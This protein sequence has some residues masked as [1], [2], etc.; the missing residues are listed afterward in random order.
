MAR[1]CSFASHQSAAAAALMRSKKGCCVGNLEGI[2]DSDSR[3]YCLQYVN[4]NESETKW[5]AAVLWSKY[6]PGHYQCANITAYCIVADMQGE[7]Y[8]SSCTV[9]ADGAPCKNLNGAVGSCWQGMCGDPERVAVNMLLAADGLRPEAL[10]WGQQT[11][12]FREQ[13]PSMGALDYDQLTFQ[14]ATAADD[15]SYSDDDPPRGSSSGGPQQPPLPQ[16]PP[17]RTQITD[18]SD[19]YGL[20]IQLPPAPKITDPFT[21]RPPS[22]PPPFP[23]PPPPPPV[24]QR[25]SLTVDIQPDSFT[26]GVPASFLGISREWTQAVWWDKNLPAFG[27]IFDVLGPAPVIRI[28][29]ASQ[30]ALLQPPNSTYINSLITLHCA[31]GVRFIIGLPLFQNAPM[32]SLAVKKTFD[33]AFK[34][35]PFAILSYELGNEPNYWPGTKQGGFQPLRGAQKCVPVQYNDPAYELVGTMDAPTDKAGGA[36]GY[37]IYKDYKEPYVP[38]KPSQYCYT[39]ES[40]LFVSGTESYQSYFARAARIITGCGGLQS[41]MQ[42]LWGFPY[43][44]PPGFNRQVISGPSWGDF[45]SFPTEQLATFLKNSDQCYLSEVTMHYYGPNRNTTFKALF[46]NLLARPIPDQ[47]EGPTNKALIS[48]V[49]SYIDAARVAN[50]ALRVSE[51]NS[52]PDGGQSNFSNTL[53]AALWTVSTAMEFA[54]AG[55]SGI[56][57]HWG[58]GGVPPDPGRAPAYI[59]VQTLFENDDWN[60]PQPAVRIPWY[61]YVMFSRALGNNGPGMFLNYTTNVKA[62]SSDAICREQIYYYP[63]L[64]PHAGMVSLVVANVNPNVTC[65]FTATLPGVLTSA[66]VLQRLEGPKGLDSVPG[67]TLAGQTYEQTRDGRMRGQ[68]TP[69]LVQP[70]QESIRQTGWTFDVRPGSGV[71]VQI[72]LAAGTTNQLGMA[73]TT[74]SFVAAAGDG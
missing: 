53:G 64:V 3:N 38:Y 72:P 23:P 14:Q 73:P 67:V 50:V 45:S 27:N 7:Q 74:P 11:Q 24:E 69:E 62:A 32:L 46:D 41:E 25:A 29:G 52:V 26:G 61:G 55:A 15:Y 51:S 2:A 39:P 1:Q 9:A 60:K 28:G 59:G 12:Q 56:N 17:P 19:P 63:L 37:A 20:N 54:R 36:P 13:G 44:G 34:D 33:D 48:V 21:P 8:G 5:N 68:F 65:E 16:Q 71:L 43:W 6:R 70:H 31:L 57:F 42:A 58:N 22:P 47:P 4:S 66:A 18:P 40:V 30:E 35:Y 49:K 10:P